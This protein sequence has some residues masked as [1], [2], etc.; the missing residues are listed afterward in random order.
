MEIIDPS[1]VST[2]RLV[3]TVRAFVRCLLVAVAA[4]AHFSSQP[5]GRME[6]SGKKCTR[7]SSK[8]DHIALRDM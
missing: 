8:R 1:G 2:A 7:S 6:N 4:H 3:A 5:P